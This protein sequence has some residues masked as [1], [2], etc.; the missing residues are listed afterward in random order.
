MELSIDAG[1]KGLLGGAWGVLSFHRAYCLVSML[2]TPGD[3]EKEEPA[4]VP[5]E[6]VC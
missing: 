2:G 6:N 3:Q 5:T 4:Q 1:T